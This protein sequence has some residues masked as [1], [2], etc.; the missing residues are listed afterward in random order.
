VAYPSSGIPPDWLEIASQNTG[1]VNDLSEFWVTDTDLASSGT[2]AFD[3]GTWAVTT[4]SAPEPSTLGLT[5][6]LGGAIL[7]IAKRR[8]RQIRHP[9]T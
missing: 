4:T 7:L 8:P 2:V 9:N 6:L 5:S 3:P 1:F